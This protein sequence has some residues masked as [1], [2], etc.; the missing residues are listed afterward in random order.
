MIWYS[1]DG[2]LTT[3][4]ITNNIIFNQTAW[5]ELSG[6]NVTITFYARDLAGNEASESVTVTKSVPSGLDPGVIITIVIV[7]IVGGVAVIAG[8]Y[9]FMKKRGIIR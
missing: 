3:Y 4:A 2:G 8:V 1:F 9:V 6:G 7:S 5:S